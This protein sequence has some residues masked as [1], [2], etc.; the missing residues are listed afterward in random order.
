[1]PRPRIAIAELS[2]ETN[3]FAA[4]RVDL[5][6][7]ERCGIVRGPA[8]IARARETATV[9]AGFI[10]AAEELGFELVP[11]LAVWITPA[12]VVTQEAY[13]T[14]VGE[15]IAGLHTAASIDGVLLSLHGAMVAEHVLDADG[16][17]LRRVRATVGPHV[18]VLA[19]LDLHANISPLM[20]EQADILI[21]YHTYPHLDQRER[22]RQAGHLLVRLLHGTIRPTAALVK[23]PMLPTSQRMTTDQPPMRTLMERAAELERDRRVLD[24]TIAGGFPPADVPE[25]G[26]SVLIT[27][28]DDPILARQLAEELAALAWELRSGFLGG[29][30][31][32]EEAADAIRSI[33]R[34][35]LVLVDI[36]DNPWSGGPG[37]SVELLRFL[38]REGVRPAAL[39][40]VR[41]PEVVE[42]CYRAGVGATVEVSLGGK[43]DDLHGP[44]LAVRGTIQLLSDGRYVNAGPMHAGVTV[45]LGRTVVLR[46]DGIDVL[47]TERAESP[48]DLNVFR[49]HGI[50]P[51][52]QRVVALKGKGHFRAAFEP[53]AERIVLVEGPGITG[54]DLRRLPFRHIRRP[55]WPLDLA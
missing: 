40:L 28:D 10:D 8:V 41:D 35:P 31:S 55:I 19:V 25:A 14:L 2:H 17:L 48:I 46:V 43:T 37:D 9:V 12:G 15:L 33:R 36:A 53:I 38:L 34:G 32:W 21:G 4:Q 5:A 39:A 47:V 42:Q 1:M 44:P 16:E 51:T 11:L 18:P 30:A 23:P 45:D 6:F 54:S 52:E 13:E 49:A 27:T 3:A 24:V 20:V 29:V 7:A 50:E 22:G 26:L